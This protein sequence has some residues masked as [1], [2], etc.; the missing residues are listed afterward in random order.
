MKSFAS[1]AEP[2]SLF[3]QVFSNWRTENPMWL[4]KNAATV[5]AKK[6]LTVVRSERFPSNKY[7]SFSDAIYLFKIN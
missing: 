4:P 2:A 1:V 6:L 5:T 7:L 3:V